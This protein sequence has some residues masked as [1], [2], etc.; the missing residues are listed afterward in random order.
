M[1]EINSKRNK[2]KIKRKTSSSSPP[3][4]PPILPPALSISLTSYPLCC[5]KSFFSSLFSLQV[6]ETNLDFAKI[7][8]GKRNSTRKR[9]TCRWQRSRIPVAIV[10]IR[11][12]QNLA[13]VS[14][15]IRE[16]DVVVFVWDNELYVED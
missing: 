1:A 15:W 16:I 6:L 14:V 4:P 5:Y 10:R 7:K 8:K 2:K 12:R 11:R 3:V 9:V 13:F